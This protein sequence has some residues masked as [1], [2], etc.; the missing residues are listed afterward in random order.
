MEWYHW[1]ALAALLFCKVLFIMYFIQIIKQ[2][3]PN[4]LAKSSGRVAKGV[5]YSYTAAMLPQ[6]KES[7]SLHL[8]T[9]TAGLIFHGGILISILSFVWFILTA[10]FGW[11]TPEIVPPLCCLCLMGAAC[12]GVGILCKR[13]FKRALRALSCADDYL[14]TGIVTLFLLATAGYFYHSHPFP[15]Y[16]I[17]SLFF[18]WLPIGKTRHLLYFFAARYQ[19][20]F[21]Y[22]RRGTWPQ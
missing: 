7:A 8:P 13:V 10:I 12:C 18:L 16:A 14:S 9:F 17:A 11:V 4:D 20:G 15:Y 2:G 6:N 19:L 3:A 1:M 21:F 22:G 5:R